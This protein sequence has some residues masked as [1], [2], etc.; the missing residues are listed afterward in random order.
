MSAD[1]VAARQSWAEFGRRL[2]TLRRS[3]G[4]TQRQL[5]LRVGYHH[6]LISKLEGGVREPP[7]GL[8]LRLDSLLGSRG[9]LLAILAGRPD[10]HHAVPMLPATL[11]STTPQGA[12]D[13]AP[14]QPVH[15][16][17]TRLVSCP[18]HGGGDCEVPPLADALTL[19]TA[20]DGDHGRTAMWPGTDADAMHALT[21]LIVGY[22]QDGL[23]SVSTET[24]GSVERVLRVV[25]RWAETL[26]RHGTL[27]VPQLRLAA[28][29]AQ[30]AGWLR[31]ERGQRI[32]GMAWF[33]R[34]LT[35]ADV[36]D[37]VV[38]RATLLCDV[39]TLV[40]LD[41]DGASALAYAQELEAVDPRRVWM[42]AMSHLH[43]ARAR[44][45]GGDLAECRKRVVLSRRALDRLDGRD[46]LE[47]P[48]LAGATGRLQVEASIGGTLRD[49]AAITGDLW[50]ARQAVK[51][52]EASLSCLPVTHR[53]TVLLL[54]L[55]LADAFVCSGQ[56]DAA[57]AA[58]A[59]VLPEAVAAD[60]TS[61][62]R[63]LDGLRTRLT[64][65]YPGAREAR[66]LLEQLPYRV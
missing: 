62:N 53:P 14:P 4:L 3:A 5:A 56:L 25:V 20:A 65:R 55:R 37:D 57:V 64:T 23:E 13:P 46:F 12:A 40:R 52:T 22:T 16:W 45:L 41:G 61:V 31:V 33:A 2:R 59:S 19:L 9:E 44:A 49:A 1:T 51:A 66:S 18:L 32:L 34:G 6:T 60:R 26:N 21:A 43:Q 63:E 42:V 30:I 58:A 39:C 10:V 38:A 17:P 15:H 47:A 35:W 29:C 8:P 7:A 50:V 36:A 48:W 11:F 54:T 24:V 27:P 28:E